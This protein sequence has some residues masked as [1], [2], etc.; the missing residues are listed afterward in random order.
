[1]KQKLANLQEVMQSLRGFLPQYLVEH[2]IDTT[3]NFS[4]LNPKH[5]DGNPSMSCRA[6]NENAYCFSCNVTMDIFQA[7][8]WLE[9]KPI[10]GATFVEENVLY[11]AEKFGVEVELEE[12]SE[13]EQYRY[14]T[15]RAYKDAAALVANPEFGDYVKFNT[16]AERRG[17]TIGHLAEAKVG[18]V[19]YK[20]FRD[21][22]KAL[23][24]EA[25]FQDEI[26]LGRPDIFSPNSMT[27]AIC[28]DKGNPVGF[29]AKNLE[30]SDEKDENGQP[31]NGS[32]YKNQR[33]TGLRCNIYQKGRRLYEIHT[34]LKFT[35]PLYVFEGYADVLTAQ[36]HGLNNCVAIGGTSFTPQHVETLKH[37]GVTSIVLVLDGDKAG[38]DRTQELLDKFFQGHKDLQIEVVNLPSELDPDDYLR[39]KSLE[40]FLGL[41]KWSAF[42][43]RLDRYSDEDNPE[44]VAKIML[45]LI[46]NEPSY[47]IQD[48]MCGE[49]SQFTGFEKR[50]LLAELERLQ[51]EKENRKQQEKQRHISNMLSEIKRNP[52]EE[53]MLLFECANQIEAV[54]EKYDESQLALESVVSFI[55]NEKGDQEALTGEFA[56]FHLSP[57]GLGGL[58][59]VLNG[60][61]RED[62][63]MCFG[64]AAN[65]GKTS[66]I[67]Q[68]AM[69]IASNPLN[70]ACVIVHTID[71]S[72]AQLLP[73]M[74]VQGYGRHDLSI[75]QVRNPNYSVKH[76][77]EIGPSVVQH[78]EDGYKALLELVRNGRIILRDASNGASFAYGENLIRYYKKKYPDRNIVYLLDNLHKTPDF[79]DM[80]PRQRFTILS[81]HMKGVAT[82]YHVC[83]GA[84]VEYTKL[85]PNTVPTNNNIAET[86][87][88]I[89][90][91]NFIGHMYNDVHERGIN[92]E[93][94]HYQQDPVSDEKVILPRVRFGIGKNKITDFKGRQFLDMWPASGIFRHV[95]TEVAELDMRARMQEIRER[96]GH[97]FNT[98]KTKTSF[99]GN[100]GDEAQWSK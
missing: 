31:K 47:I 48:R 16:E 5:D 53:R 98:N 75:N 71:D 60:N 3:N 35:P 9:D 39:E 49:L 15:Y 4:C 78:R 10:D 89:Y 67:C 38:R 13:E 94:C 52:G 30:Y 11:L 1:M 37:S 36:Q 83:I 23:G 61:W 54:E 69:E 44:D 55:E 22:L 91:A 86:R 42:E 29:A 70:N 77:P 28:D 17:W 12:M 7:A 63:L 85:P 14:R 88:I 2:D 26:D 43:W 25:R 84:T 92:A 18:T 59:A 6:N 73:R 97:R 40:D 34:A 33:T 95:P 74:V 66:L 80:E 64:G 99:G 93:C 41:K 8:H 100:D 32:K 51:N 79:K 65:T 62:V 24:Y 90:D 81:N 96:N 19:D 56:G 27:F 72:A 20:E 21:A 58:G 46:V 50:T 87:A 76:E 68:L 57:L 45:P 82:K